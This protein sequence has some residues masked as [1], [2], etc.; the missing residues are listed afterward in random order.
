VTALTVSAG[1]A[2]GGCADGDACGWHA[3][4]ATI[5]IVAARATIRMF[6][7]IFIV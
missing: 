6:L 2:A 3:A 1:R 7:H 4:T 5:A